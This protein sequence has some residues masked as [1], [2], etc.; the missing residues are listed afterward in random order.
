VQ[1]TK[2][3]RHSYVGFKINGAKMEEEAYKRLSDSRWPEETL[4][5]YHSFE[6]ACHWPRCAPANNEKSA[7]HKPYTFDLLERGEEGATT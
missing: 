2:F 1:R 6:D 5:H 7:C 3:A 4:V